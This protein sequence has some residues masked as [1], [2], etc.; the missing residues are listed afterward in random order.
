MKPTRAE[1]EAR[2]AIALN[3]GS[4]AQIDD[5]VGR[6]TSYLNRQELTDNTLIIYTSVVFPQF[7]RRFS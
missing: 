7:T 1:E 5:S 2:W 4:L 3:Y 6:L